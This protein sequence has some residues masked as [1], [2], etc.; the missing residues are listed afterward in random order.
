[1]INK[2][3]IS[4]RCQCTSIHRCTESRLM[5]S[6]SFS[7]NM[8]NSDISCKGKSGRWIGPSC[9]QMLCWSRSLFSLFFT[10]VRHSD[11]SSK[12]A[13]EAQ[14]STPAASPTLIPNQFTSSFSVSLLLWVVWHSKVNSRNCLFIVKWFLIGT[15]VY[16]VGCN[17]KYYW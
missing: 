2:Q 17:E 14:R 5:R 6:V 15:S 8:Y 11:V 16:C 13:H 9:D 4:R 10:F 1:M 12:I 3:T 7:L